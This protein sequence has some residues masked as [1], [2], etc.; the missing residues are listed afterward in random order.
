LP[1]FTGAWH[2]ACCYSSFNLYFGGTTMK[3]IQI[4]LLLALFLP[5]AA[6]VSADSRP[7]KSSSY[8]SGFSS[9]KSSSTSSNRSSSSSSATSGRNGGFGSFGNSAPRQER[10][11]MPQ[12]SDSALSQSMNK[13]NAQSNALRTLEARRAA[14]EAARAPKEMQP[15]PAGP[16]PA[17]GQSGQYGNNDSRRSADNGQRNSGGNSGYGSGGYNGGYNGGGMPA[18][19]IVQQNSGLVNMITG[20]LLAKATSSNQPRSNT[21][22]SYP[23]NGS[24]S[25]AVSSDNS[26]MAAAAGAN[27]IPVQSQPKSSWGMAILRTMAWLAILAVLGWLVYFGWKFLRRGKAPSTANYSFERN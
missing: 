18:P 13:S 26:G 11:A 24:S 5:V 7:S 20:F 22:N 17:N 16:L 19:V 9:Q 3:S 8:K 21:N 4:A 2:H 27:G 15:V 12:R 10:Q 1:F 14:Q 23:N 6:E 25:G